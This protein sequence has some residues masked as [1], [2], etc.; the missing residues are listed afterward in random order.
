M[1]VQVCGGS[2]Q[3]RVKNKFK[4][5]EKGSSFFTENVIKGWDSADAVEADSA[6]RFKKGL[7]MYW[8]KGASITIEHGSEGDIREL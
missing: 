3:Q 5:D 4:T 6:A 7:D 1:S 8:K 2:N